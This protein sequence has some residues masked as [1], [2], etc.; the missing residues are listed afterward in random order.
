MLLLKKKMLLLL[1]IITINLPIAS[2][3]TCDSKTIEKLKVIAQN[4]NISEAESRNGDNI[5]HN[6]YD[7]YISGLPSDFIVKYQKKAYTLED[8]NEENIVVIDSLSPGNK[9]LEIYSKSCD[10]R[11]ET[12]TVELLKYNYYSESF[13][14]SNLEDQNIEVCDPWYQGDIDEETFN[15]IIDSY[16]NKDSSN[17]SVIEIL[18]AF[19]V[20]NSR[21]LYIIVGA[22]IVIIIIIKIM[23]DRKRSELL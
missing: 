3:T 9:Y 5:I 23:I 7:I 17:N 4:I 2:A 13:E 22:I 16:K 20:E 8:S 19:I 6:V 11:L 12:R 18:K 14:C 1:M 21:T 10:Q 15:Q